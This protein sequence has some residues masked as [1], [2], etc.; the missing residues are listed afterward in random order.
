MQ[1]GTELFLS[2]KQQRRPLQP[3]LYSIYP[4]SM[5]QHDDFLA[6]RHR[7]D[8]GEEQGGHLHVR[9]EHHRG[10]AQAALVAQ[11]HAQPGALLPHRSESTRSTTSSQVEECKE[12]YFLT[13][14]R[15][16]V[17]P[18]ALLSRNMTM[19]RFIKNV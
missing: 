19:L 9:T 11:D 12:H 15:V 17:S 1:Q 5:E 3:L 14:Q 13:G 6:G 16:Q 7:K 8:P 4:S 18:G 10:G 2:P